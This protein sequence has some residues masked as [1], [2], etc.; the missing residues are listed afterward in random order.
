MREP[1]IARNY[2]E[3]LLALATKS[4]DLD[5][6]GNMI[7]DIARAVQNDITLQRF[8]D[9]PSV[10]VPQ[11]NEVLG[12]A[13]QDRYPR[14]FVRFLQAVISHRRERLIPQIATQYDNLVDEQVG[15]VH[16]EVTMAH[17]PD[18]E[19]QGA[20]QRELSRLFGK[21]VVPHFQLRPEILGGVIVRMEDRV[22]DGSV[23]HRLNALRTQLMAAGASA[24]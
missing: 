5:G 23:R 16:A 8:L 22:I 18:V 15:R 11:K 12:R 6:W 4:G 1:T 2:A 9:S 13:F 7:R 3:S 21:T 14:L 24:R 19:M 20:I 10:S 17:Q